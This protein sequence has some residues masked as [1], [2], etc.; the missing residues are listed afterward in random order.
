MQPVLRHNV[1]RA[2]QYIQFLAMQS[3]DF[4]IHHYVHRRIESEGYTP[5][6]FVL[7]QRVLEVRT[8]VKSGQIAN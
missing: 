8:V 1:E 3:E 2:G 4:S 7:G 5:H 6:G